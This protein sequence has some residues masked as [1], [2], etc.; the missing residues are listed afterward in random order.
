MSLSF[1]GRLQMAAISEQQGRLLEKLLLCP[2]W[3]GTSLRAMHG[4]VQGVSH[5]FSREWAAV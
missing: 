3:Q 1:L 5:Q 2:S 4:L